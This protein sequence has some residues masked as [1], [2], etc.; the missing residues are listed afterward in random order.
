MFIFYLVNYK[1]SFMKLI[2][3]TIK[4]KTIVSQRLYKNKVFGE[5]KKYPVLFFILLS[6]GHFGV[7]LVHWIATQNIITHQ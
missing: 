6:K 1:S 7:G 3:R 2:L 4:G 5:A